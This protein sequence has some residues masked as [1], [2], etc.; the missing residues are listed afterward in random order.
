VLAESSTKPDIIL[1]GTGSE[2]QFVIGAYEQLA[3]NGIAVRVVSMP[4][5]E[6][7]EQQPKEYRETVFTPSIKKRLAVEAGVPMGWHKYVG[8]EGS[9][10]GMTTFGASAPY[11]VLYKQYGFTVEN[12]LKRAKEILG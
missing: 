11:E 4:S 2:V 12:V 1:I 7:F 10:I 3:K 6:L 9:V 5:W 8:D